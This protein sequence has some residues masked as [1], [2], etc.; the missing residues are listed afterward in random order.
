MSNQAKDGLKPTKR[1]RVGGDWW[2]CTYLSR[3]EKFLFS[4]LEIALFVTGV[5]FIVGFDT[6][7]WPILM[8]YFLACALIFMGAGAI[9]RALAF[10]VEHNR[11]CNQLAEEVEAIVKNGVTEDETSMDQDCGPPNPRGRD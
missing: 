5:S 3:R 8:A 7:T 11:M 1:Y 9:T 6:Y 10:M 2:L 4:L